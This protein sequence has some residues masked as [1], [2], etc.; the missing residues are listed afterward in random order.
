MLSVAL[1]GAPKS[2]WVNHVTEQEANPLFNIDSVTWEDF[3][4]FLQN[5]LSDP[6]TRAL[7]AAKRLE[8]LAQG[9]HETVTEFLDRY[10]NIVADLPYFP[11]DNQRIIHLLPKFRSEVCL[12]ISCQPLPATYAQLVSTAR[13]IEDSQRVAG[14][15]KYRPRH[16]NNPHYPQ[17]DTQPAPAQRPLA[18]TAAQNNPF[19]SRSNRQC[20]RCG[21]EGHLMRDCRSSTGTTPPNPNPSAGAAPTTRVRCYTCDE[22]GHYS[23]TCPRATCR[24]C[25]QAGHTASKCNQSHAT[26]PNVAPLGRDRS[27]GATQ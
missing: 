9:D 15:S 12:A 6:E 17:Q 10:A 18:D 19:A 20:Y 2:A 7:A 16:P 25:G 21:R 23:T 14:T 3:V 11:S 8:Y 26:L 13:R 4:S 1:S 24:Q 27:S 5:H 22:L